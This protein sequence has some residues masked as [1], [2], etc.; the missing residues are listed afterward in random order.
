MYQ[1][2][3]SVVKWFYSEISTTI[4]KFRIGMIKKKIKKNSGKEKVFFYAQPGC[5]Y[6]IKEFGKI[7]ILWNI[8]AI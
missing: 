7:V 2:E 6:L 3:F 5:L 4:Q 8:I 1:T